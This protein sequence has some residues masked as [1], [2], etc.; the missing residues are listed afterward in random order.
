VARD[1]TSSSALSE[2]LG[3]VRSGLVVEERGGP[4]AALESAAAVLVG[5]ADPVH[6]AVEET[7]V[8]VVSFV[9][10]SLVVV[11]VASTDAAAPIHRSTQRADRLKIARRPTGQR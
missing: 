3:Q 2:D 4:S 1:S 11:L 9:S 6:H 10:R 7:N 8:V 5:R